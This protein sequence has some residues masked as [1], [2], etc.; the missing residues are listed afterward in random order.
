MGYHGR[1]LGPGD[2]STSRPG[3]FCMLH[4]VLAYIDPGSGSL[5]IQALIASVIAIPVILRARIAQVVRAFRRGKP[6]ADGADD[7]HAAG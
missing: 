7:G 1:A 2:R 5:I 6:T 4:P 3:D